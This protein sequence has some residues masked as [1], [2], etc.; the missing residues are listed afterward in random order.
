[1]AEITVSAW[2][3]NSEPGIRTGERRPE[4]SGSPSCMR[5][6]ESASEPSAFFSSA[7]GAVRNSNF[8]PSSMASSTSMACAGISLRVRRYTM[9]TSPP[10]RSAVR[11]QSMAVLPPPTTMVRPGFGQSFQFFPAMSPSHWMPFCA[12]SSPS[13]RME[14]DA[15]EPTARITASKSCSSCSIVKSLPRVWPVR[16]S[17]PPILLKWASS[18]RSVSFGRRNSGM[19]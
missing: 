14:L 10:R 12:A 5:A 17:M 18:L 4:A 16:I 2:S 8:T 13:M 6:Q 3:L 1:M 11:A 19:P 15:Q 7:A 9:V